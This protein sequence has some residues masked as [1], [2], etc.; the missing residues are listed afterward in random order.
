MTCKDEVIGTRNAP[1]DDGEVPCGELTLDADL[2]AGVFGHP[3][4]AP[5]LNSCDVQFWYGHGITGRQRL[6]R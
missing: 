3:R 6:R 4:G 2:V 5:A 1:L